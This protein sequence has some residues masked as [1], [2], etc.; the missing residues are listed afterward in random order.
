[1]LLFEKIMYLGGG[2]IT[3]RDQAIKYKGFIWQKYFL[4]AT[5]SPDKCIKLSVI[6]IKVLFYR[7]AVTVQRL[8][9]L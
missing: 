4:T 1:M 8:A 3:E 9:D 5:L 7:S 6:H 2:S